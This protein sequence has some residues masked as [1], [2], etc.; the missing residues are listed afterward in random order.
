MILSTV[1]YLRNGNDW[2]MMHRTLKAQD[3]NHGK[4]IGVGGKFFPGE[5]PDEAA[6]REI[7]EE[8]DLEPQELVARGMLTFLYHDKAPEYIMVFTAEV[9][10]RE[11]SACD[12]G[13]LAWIPEEELM[14]LDLWAGDRIFLPLL[15]EDV[16]FFRLKLVYD[17]TDQL[18][19]FVLN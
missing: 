19:E 17:E 13:I 12:E 9:S 10:S 6:K 5:S 4:W 18:L 7:L 1:C 3:V 15:L 14:D 2:L 11:V 16:P 8:T